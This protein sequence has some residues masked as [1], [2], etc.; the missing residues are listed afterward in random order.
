MST[1]TRLSTPQRKLLLAIADHRAGVET[2]RR[3]GILTNFCSLKKL[4]GLQRRSQV[5]LLD[6]GYLSF[7]GTRDYITLT[8][9][10]RAAITATRRG[11]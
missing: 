5:L 1:T 8:D 4:T 7:T 10:G 11:P 6:M 2:S 9:K 3:D